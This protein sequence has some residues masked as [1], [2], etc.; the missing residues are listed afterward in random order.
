MG[1]CIRG[2]LRAPGPRLQLAIEAQPFSIGTWYVPAEGGKLISVKM[3]RRGLQS[4]RL[5]L[6]PRVLFV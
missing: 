5:A 4:G 2:V 6:D 3:L 1:D